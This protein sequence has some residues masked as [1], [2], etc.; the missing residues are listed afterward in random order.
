MIFS[1]VLTVAVCAATMM[2]LAQTRPAARQK[3]SPA[4]SAPAA[5]PS[6]AQVEPTAQKP[7][8]LP[9]LVLMVVV[10][11]FRYDYLER[12]RQDYS[13]GLQRLLAEGAVF[14]DA[15]YDHSPTVTAVGH[16][17]VLSGAMPA[18]S[19]IVGNEYYDR[20]IGKQVESTSDASTR[21]V[22]APSE[23]TSSSPR[24][25]LVS[26][27]GDEIKMSGRWPSK[28]V[29]ISFKDRA[30]IMPAG[31]MADGAYWWDTGSGNFVSSTF[32]MNDLPP[33]AAEFNKG[34]A[35]DQYVGKTWTPSFG[36]S[37]FMMLPGQPGRPYWSGVVGTSY[38]N[39]LLAMFAEAAI[40]GEKLGQRDA[41][42][43]L[44]I[45]FSSCDTIGHRKGPHAPEIRDNA[46]ATDRAV[47]R[48]L[49]HLE[50][51][52]GLKNV[53]VIYTADHGVAPMPEFMAERK[54]PGGRAKEEDVLDAVQKALTAKY[55]EGK[56]VVGKSGPAPYLDHALVARKKLSL[57]DVQATAA[58]AVRDLPYVAR[59][60]TREDLRRGQAVSD[61][62]GRRVQNG[63]FYLRASDLFVVPQPYWLFEDSGTSHGT[64]WIYD[65]HVPLIFHGPGIKP[66]RYHRR[67]LVNDIA[68]TL[69]AILG[70]ETPSGASGRVLEEALQTSR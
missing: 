8:P 57:D 66:G 50:K 10:D 40:D 47:G 38:G 3:P 29:G 65:S 5:S 70:V 35:V 30:A 37:P 32:Y 54:M 31:R 15:H 46:I 62:I 13:A 61:L 60:F 23:K 28:V 26:T 41:V 14:T 12:F 34:R 43:V 6:P 67:A 4:K 63:F 24:R 36:G 17:I 56:W 68:P 42:D 7:A 18:T 52:V 22:G 58:Q 16:S 9:K 19:G 49:D 48:V 59:V 69:S 55:G 33:W 25:L 21:L 27:L 44:T 64:P 2:L 45:S 20:T 51:R 39:D 1:K 11:Q 53:L